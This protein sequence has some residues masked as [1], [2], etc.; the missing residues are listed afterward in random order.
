MIWHLIK[1]FLKQWIFIVWLCALHCELVFFSFLKN[2]HC[3]CCCCSIVV[4]CVC[5]CDVCEY[6]YMYA[7]ACEWKSEDSLQELILFPPWVVGIKLGSFGLGCKLYCQ[8]VHLVYLTT[9]FTR[10]NYLSI[11]PFYLCAYRRLA[12]S[13]LWRHSMHSAIVLNNKSLK[14]LAPRTTKIPTWMLIMMCLPCFF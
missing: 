14:N 10:K 9:V 6:R 13:E 12:F 3:C 8:L 1:S 11:M 2:I 5:A 7:T 4:C